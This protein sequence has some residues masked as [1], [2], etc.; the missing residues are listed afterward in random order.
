VFTTLH[1]IFEGAEPL[2]YVIMLI[3]LNIN[4]GCV[5]CFMFLAFP[6]SLLVNLVLEDVLFSVS[7]FLI[8]AIFKNKTKQNNDKTHQVP[9]LFILFGSGAGK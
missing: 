5:T 2:L 7:P 6:L 1:Y 4:A 3:N 9:C 8:N